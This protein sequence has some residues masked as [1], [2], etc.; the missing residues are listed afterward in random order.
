[1]PRPLRVVIA[2][3]E[4]VES[5][6][7]FAESSQD[8]LD[9]VEYVEEGLRQLGHTSFRV[10]FAGHPRQELTALEAAAPDVIFNLV[11]SI[12]EEAR[13]FP[14]FGGLL[15]IW[16]APFTGS[17]SFA[18]AV[19][20]DKRLT[21][22]ALRGGGLATPDWTV[23]TDA[24]NLDLQGV[25]GPWLVKP[26]FEDGSIGSDADSLY[27]GPDRLIAG[28]PTFVQAH[29][30]QPLLVEHYVDGRELNVSLIGPAGHMDP[31]P[32]VEIDFSAFG[33]DRPKIYG[34]RA[35]WQC[36]SF[37]YQHAKRMLHT[38]ASDPLVPEL[39]ALATRACDLLGVGGYARVDFRVSP[40]GTPYILEV[41][42]NPCLTDDASF[43]AAAYAGGLTQADIIDRILAA[44]FQW[45]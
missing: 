13:L 5:D 39:Q 45:I 12:D 41:N 36:D 3:N 44:A 34:Y 15:E 8:V 17:R 31:L 2:H 20:T 35:K 22:L 14:S 4:P 37:E 26:V 28:L 27:D 11:E 24:R 1:M 32:V 25:P 23:C 19:T 10:P 38:S 42:T 16:G 21:K 40:E 33:A 18:L 6:E 29:E 43:T 9:Q 30:G 7:P